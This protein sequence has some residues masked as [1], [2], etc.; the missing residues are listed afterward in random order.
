MNRGFGQLKQLLS[1]L[2]SARSEAG[3]RFAWRAAG[4]AGLASLAGVVMGL[5][6]AFVGLGVHSLGGQGPRPPG[7]LAFIERFA[8]PG[9]ATLGLAVLLVAAAVLF[10]FAS[11]RMA[12][13]FS[14]EA[15]RDL[16]RLMMARLLTASP[17]AIDALGAELA[18]AKPGPA[19]P[20]I[21]L[22]TPP[23]ADAIKLA[24]LRDG[25]MAA[26][27][28]VS[29]ISSLPQTLVGL[30]TLGL[31]LALSG[32]GLVALIGVFVFA[33]SRLLSA[34][35][36]RRMAER[37]RALAQADAAAF[38]EVSEKLACLDDFRLAG[39]GLLARQETDEALS[40]AAEG[41]KEVAKVVAESGQ[42]ASLVTTL[43]PLLV[44]IFLH[45]S[46]RTVSPPEIAQLLVSLPLIVGRLGALDGLRV[47]VIEKQSV[48][49]SIGAILQVP[50][51]TGAFS[52][53]VALPKQ[54]L[55]LVFEK[56]GF[57]LKTDGRSKT[58]LREVSLTIPEGSVVGLCGPSG[59]GKSTLLRLLL[60][61]DDPSS[62]V[63][64]VGEHPIAQLSPE[65]LSQ[66]FAAELQSGKLLG[67]SIRDNVL[68][69]ALSLEPTLAEQEATARARAALELAQIP[70]LAAAEGLAKRFVAVPPNLSGGEQ[71]RVLVARALASSARVI[72]LDEPEAGLPDDTAKKLFDAVIANRAG[73]TV[74]AVTHSPA[75]FASDFN[76]V[77]E[78]GEVKDVGPHATL[79]ERCDAYKALVAGEGAKPKPPAPARP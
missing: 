23:S 34:R 58:I 31:D 8:L 29:A 15:T 7:M 44:L 76:V 46:G 72:V 35:S 22:K 28:C 1:A 62:G 27:L 3:P 5:V 10:G 11:S 20:G 32:S 38:A 63:L 43:A 24:V 19:P 55:D 2:A 47:A 6:P 9:W 52:P 64:R 74:I 40:K 78:A 65:D 4:V 41:K 39:A 67:R 79:L 70:S 77:M 54:G 14:A 73:R 48:L 57:E 18:G 37:T 25:Q 36:S 45:L 16:R 21:V 53:S 12:A 75:L 49:E 51:A 61:L 66:V 69:H 68:L 26:E 59:C 56:V 30:A 50:A 42:I 33:T 13:V 60:R 71:K 17:R